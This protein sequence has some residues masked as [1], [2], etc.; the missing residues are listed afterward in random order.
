MTA[1]E[2][3]VMQEIKSRA[4]SNTHQID[5]LKVR[6]EK[7]EAKSETL[8]QMSENIALMAQSLKQVEGD[9][10]E[11]KENQKELSDK[12]ST[13]ENAPANETLNNLKKIKV[14]A[15][16]AVATMIATGVAG[17]IIVALAK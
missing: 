2:V 10:G 7:Q 6:M 12:V 5:E 17:A 15:I 9:V 8:Y 11:V 1:E 16:T 13:L 3:R 4:E 14:A